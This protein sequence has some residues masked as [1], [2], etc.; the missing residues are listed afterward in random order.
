VKGSQTPAASKDG[1]AGSG[2][3][4]PRTLHNVTS[5]G[6]SEIKWVQEFYFADIRSVIVNEHSNT[7]GEPLEQ[8]EAERYYKEVGHDGRGLRVPDDLDE[9]ICLYQRLP[10]A[11]R[12]KF[13][14]AMYWMN[15]SRRQW[16]DSMSASFIS[17]VS[18]VEALADQQSVKHHVY[19]EECQNK[20]SHDVPG[21]TEKFRTFFER[22]VPDPGLRERRSKM[23]A[24]RSK[25]A[26][27]SE[28]LQIDVGRAFG[29]DPPYWNEREL[30]WELS[31]LARAAARN[32]LRNPPVA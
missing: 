13:D 4:R 20:R 1:A 31:S 21:A 9:S 27:G 10:D 3:R 29:W 8:V 14:R 25:I 28:L 11:L 15:L 32:W 5:S 24:M 19:C 22:Y 30:N 26:H 7:S 16:E 6:K 12:R 23:Y 18:A 2:G 17:L